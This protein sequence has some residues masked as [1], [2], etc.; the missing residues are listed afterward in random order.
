MRKLKKVNRRGRNRVRIVLLSL[1]ASLTVSACDESVATGPEI[2]VPAGL[3]SRIETPSSQLPAAYQRVDSI[4]VYS[5]AGAQKAVVRRAD[6]RNSASTVPRA[7]AS[8]ADP[9][10]LRMRLEQVAPVLKGGTGSVA[11]MLQLA[12]ALEA[13]TRENHR[14]VLA[15][16]PLSVRI[17]S[18]RDGSARRDF[19]VRGT[20]KLSVFGA[21]DAA[22]PMPQRFAT[23]R[24]GVPSAQSASSLTASSDEDWCTTEFQGVVYYDECA[25]QQ[26]VDD[27]WATIAALDYEVDGLESQFNA[28]IASH[29]G[30]DPYACDD[31]PEPESGEEEIG[32]PTVVA[33]GIPGRVQDHL[34][35]DARLRPSDDEDCGHSGSPHLVV[36]SG[37]DCA[38]AAI[39]AVAGLYGFGLAKDAAVGLLTSA[40][41]VTARR[42]LLVGLGGTVTA[43]LSVGIGVG[44]FLECLA[45]EE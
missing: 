32:A 13:P 30:G 25:T 33:G 44:A 36:A 40:V 6:L 2:D 28:A 39:S 21:T 7:D 22:D 3:K 20:L 37:G 1:M 19:Y 12:R 34:L 23:W 11:M 5:N 9:A 31:L 26:D 15:K 45:V 10:A 29:C 24:G 8:F 18:A 17:S 27:G 35:L 38:V 14:N 16:L 4:V 41:K 42:A 43:A